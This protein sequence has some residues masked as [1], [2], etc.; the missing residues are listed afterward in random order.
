M[1]SHIRFEALQAAKATE[2]GVEGGRGFTPGD[3]LVEAMKSVPAM[4]FKDDFSLARYA[5][6]HSPYVSSHVRIKASLP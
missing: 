2:P 5:A 4:F 3:G 6:N 1:Y